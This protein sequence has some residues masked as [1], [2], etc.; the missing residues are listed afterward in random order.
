[1][2]GAG[3]GEGGRGPGE[4]MG[5]LR[6]AK[7]TGHRSVGI[8]DE[9]GTFSDLTGQTNW[10]GSYHFFSPFPNSLI[11]S[12][13]RFAR[14]FGRNIPTEI[15]EW[16]TSGG[17]PQYSGHKKPK[18]AFQLKFLESLAKWKAPHF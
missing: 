13:N 4:C 18:R 6:Y 9:N 5:A 14:R 11:R 3:R 10:N 12:K 2:R 15:N 17:D 1:M 8:P 16:N 7:L